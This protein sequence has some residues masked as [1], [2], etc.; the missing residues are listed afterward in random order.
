MDSVAIVSPVEANSSAAA[1][2]SPLASAGVYSAVDSV[3]VSFLAGV[4]DSVV[5]PRLSSSV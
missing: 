2:S 3:V 5:Y 4:Y 1:S